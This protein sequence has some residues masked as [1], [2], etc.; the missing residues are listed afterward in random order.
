M[1]SKDLVHSSASSQ[2]CPED[3]PIFKSGNSPL[4][5]SGKGREEEGS[6][7]QDSQVGKT[8]PRPLGVA[9]VQSGYLLLK[10]IGRVPVP[11]EPTSAV[12]LGLDQSCI[13]QMDR[14]WSV[15]CPSTCGLSLMP[16][17]HAARAEAFRSPGW[18]LGQTTFLQN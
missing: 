11:E 10:L 3:R 4:L 13:L 6:L 16:V 17:G 12:G 9:A 18:Q 2:S 14:V 5:S 8:L 7:C 1:S 15:C